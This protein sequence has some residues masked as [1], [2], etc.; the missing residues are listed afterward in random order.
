VCAEKRAP[1][2]RCFRRPLWVTVSAAGLLLLLFTLVPFP[3]ISRL[4]REAPREAA[5]LAAA[6]PNLK[7]FD[8][9]GN[10]R[11]LLARSEVIHG[12]MMRRGIVL[13]GEE[14]TGLAPER[15]FSEKGVA[16]SPDPAEEEKGKEE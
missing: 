3:P 5:R 14:P 12:I 7:R 10:Q 1:V 11:Y 9:S 13:S 6:L 16:G 8:P 4:S 15:A 2:K